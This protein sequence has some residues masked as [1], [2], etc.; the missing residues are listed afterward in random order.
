MALQNAF[1][2]ALVTRYLPIW[3]GTSVAVLDV[4]VVTTVSGS[5]LELVALAWK[6]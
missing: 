1:Q 3:Q 5:V 6:A 2:F 4:S